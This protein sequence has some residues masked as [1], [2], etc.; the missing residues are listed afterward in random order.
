MSDDKR[1][2]VE[3]GAKIAGLVAGAREAAAVVKESTTEMKEHG[4]GLTR[5]F[6]AVQ[7]HWAALLAVVAGGA[8]FKEAIESTVEWTSEVVMLS[9]RLGITTEDASGLAVALQHVG[10]APTSTRAREQAHAPDAHERA[11]LRHA[12]HQDEGSERPVAELAGRHG[13]RD[14]EAQRHEGRH[15]SQRRRAGAPR[16]ARRQPEPDPPPERGDAGRS[17]PRRRRSI[18][19]SSAPRARRRCSPTR[20]RWPICT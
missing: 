5:V 13:R 10:V 11:G 19:S 9:K 2:D 18:T 4:E 12:R 16:R 20:T 15:R 7:A 6:E 14:R 17:R 8:L 1:V 3:F